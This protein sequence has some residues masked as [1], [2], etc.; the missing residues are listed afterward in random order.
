VGRRS[1]AASGVEAN[2]RALARHRT[3]ASR[4]ADRRK[5]PGIS[6]NELARILHMHKSTITFLVKRLV[7]RG[8]LIRTVD[9]EDRRRATLELTARGRR[10]DG[11]RG[12]TVEA[13]VRRALARVPGWALASGRQVLSVLAEELTR[14]LPGK[15]TQ[16]PA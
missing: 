12:G 8:A 6:P 9:P 3:A 11:I 5:I 16:S 15:K 7:E 1:R 13:A 4:G 14:P 2:E 10:I